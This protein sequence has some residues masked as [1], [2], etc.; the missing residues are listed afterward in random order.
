MFNQSS[1]FSVIRIMIIVHKPFSNVNFSK[2][3]VAA[4]NQILLCYTYG[5]INQFFK[6]Q[7]PVTF[8]LDINF[9]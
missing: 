5:S 8:V 1:S 3:R 9:L 7:F 2:S 6:E 4:F